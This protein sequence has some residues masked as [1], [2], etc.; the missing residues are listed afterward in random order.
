M[1]KH[2]GLFQ[3]NG[4]FY[5][6]FIVPT[7]Q[8]HLFE[9][10]SRIVKSLGTQSAREAKFQAVVLRAQWLSPSVSD[11]DV[12]RFDVIVGAAEGYTIKSL[13]DQWQETKKPSRD[14]YRACELAVEGLLSMLGLSDIAPDGMTRRSAR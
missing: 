8:R 7:H 13:L 2:T 11:K 14:T 12:L 5:L 9:G 6:R 10:R 3:R 4:T 1:A